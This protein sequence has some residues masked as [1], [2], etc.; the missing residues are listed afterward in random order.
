L[1]LL[2]S[3]L[4][5]HALG[6]V[7]I[8]APEVILIRGALFLVP[9]S[10]P[11]TASAKSNSKGNPG[12]DR[13]DTTGRGRN[14]NDRGGVAGSREP[15]PSQVDDGRERERGSDYGSLLDEGGGRSE[16]SL[17]KVPTN[18]KVAVA[19]LIL[20]GDTNTPAPVSVEQSLQLMIDLNLLTTEQAK[21]VYSELLTGVL[22]S[23]AHNISARQNSLSANAAKYFA[24]VSGTLD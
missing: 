24:F 8:F 7:T 2:L 10:L 3:P 19:G 4:S 22:N 17:F 9:M 11:V 20:D 15:G 12:E 21:S 14:S 16:G 1:G 13:K 23:S 18:T 5:S 6:V